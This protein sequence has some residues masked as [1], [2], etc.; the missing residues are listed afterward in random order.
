MALVS[1][2][3]KE[4][5]LILNQS[6]NNN[7]V[8]GSKFVHLIRKVNHEVETVKE[9]I[10][11]LQVVCR[12]G[13]QQVDSLSGGNQQKV[14]LSK[15]LMRKP[16]ILI[17]DEPTKGIDV[18]AKAEV[19]AIISDLATKGT[20]VLLISSEEEEIMGMC[21]RAV[22]LYEGKTMGVLDRSEFDENKILNLAHGFVD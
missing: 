7:A 19:H 16:D 15:W 5:G 22:V 12:D 4:L 20:S 2:D 3:R 18:G 6:I 10:D 8:I 11:K 13:F 14:V 17:L 21:D 1:E 9:Y